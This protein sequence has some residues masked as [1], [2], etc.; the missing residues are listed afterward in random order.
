MENSGLNKIGNWLIGLGCLIPVILIVSLVISMAGS[1]QASSGD[2]AALA[3]DMA[4]LTVYLRQQPGRGAQWPYMDEDDSLKIV[5]TQNKSNAQS[6]A[7]NCVTEFAR[8]RK[9]DG[10]SGITFVFVYDG[11]DNKLAS[12]SL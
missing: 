9:K 8:L 5:L 7:D 4:V 10:F 2:K 6:V 3:N 12:A 11:E 1:H